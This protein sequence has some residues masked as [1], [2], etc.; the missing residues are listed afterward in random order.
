MT[1]DSDPKSI[2]SGAYVYERDG[3]IVAKETWSIK[4]QPNGTQ[5]IKSHRDANQFGAQIS[6]EAKLG[7]GGDGDY[8]FVWQN[9]P[10]EQLVHTTAYRLRGNEISCRSKNFGTIKLGHR[11]AT[12]FFPLMRV[13]T[14]N[15]ILATIEMGGTATWVV[16]DISDPQEKTT[17]FSPNCSQRTVTREDGYFQLAGGPYKTPARITLRP[18][19]LLKNY[20]FTSQDGKNYWVCRYVSSQT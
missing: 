5:Q 1:G 7:I 16:P 11:E 14:G 19:G 20:E 9:A 10:Q 4:T 2:V 3:I 13:F 8:R 15:A 6:V 12:V 17:L 18:D